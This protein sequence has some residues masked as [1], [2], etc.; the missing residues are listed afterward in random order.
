MP[1]NTQTASSHEEVR[2]LANTAELLTWLEA[3]AEMK[4]GDLSERDAR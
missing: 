4:L 1:V 2:N 3:L